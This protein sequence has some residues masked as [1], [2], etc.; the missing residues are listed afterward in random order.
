MFIAINGRPGVGK[1]PV[2]RLL[3]EQLGARLVDAHSLYNLA[4]SLTEKG[5][6]A[7]QKCVLDLRNIAREHVLS[8]SQATPIITT[9][10]LFEDSAW[11]NAIWEV[12]IRLARDRNGPF[13]GVILDCDPEENELR[14][15][16]PER[17]GKR[18]PM[19]GSVL[20]PNRYHRNLIRRGTDDLLQINTTKLSVEETTAK[21]EAWMSDYSEC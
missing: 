3:S 18:K 10:A 19:D 1:L 21:I 20:S 13:L 5:S 9:D 16:S 12:T 7:F 14:L 4:F 6:D 11:G 15:R 8:L 17:Q 2:G